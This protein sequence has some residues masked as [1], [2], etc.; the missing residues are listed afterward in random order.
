MEGS[1]EG[2]AGCV[3][4]G[5]CVTLWV[6]AMLLSMA[7]MVCLVCRNCEHAVMGRMICWEF[8]KFYC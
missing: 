1:G 4:Y 2:I 8:T 6:A 5:E 3:V 7:G